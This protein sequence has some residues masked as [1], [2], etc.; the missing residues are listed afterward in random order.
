MMEP[1]FSQRLIFPATV[2]TVVGQAN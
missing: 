1:A 2:T